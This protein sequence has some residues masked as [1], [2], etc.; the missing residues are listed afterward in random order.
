MHILTFLKIECLSTTATENFVAT[1]TLNGNIVVWSV[2][3][4]LK[5]ILAY[6]LTKKSNTFFFLRTFI[7]FFRQNDFNRNTASLTWTRPVQ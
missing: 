5:V 1:S 6:F 3:K 4:I 2:D 7:T